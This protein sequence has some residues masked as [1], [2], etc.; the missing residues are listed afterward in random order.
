[1][2]TFKSIFILSAIL[3][4][5]TAC[6]QEKT[7]E[8][9]EEQV[10]S[11]IHS[12]FE[13]DDGDEIIDKLQ[14]SDTTKPSKFSSVLLFEDTLK[15]LYDA[16]NVDSIT[17][18]YKVFR[19]AMIG[20]YSLRQ[21]GR[22]KNNNEIISIIDFT[23]PSTE[24]RFYTIDL[25]NKQYVFNT[26]VSHGRNTGG[27]KATKFSN[28][29]QSFQTSLGLCTT[30]KT[31]VGSK[32][33]SMRL[34]GEEAGVNDNVFKRAIVMHDAPYVSES[35]IK[36]YGRIG[37]SLGC[38]AIP[39]EIAK[40][41]INTIK[42]GTVLFSYYNDENYIKASKFLNIEALVQKMNLNELSKD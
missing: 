38:P 42:D 40:E 24:K 19:F 22:L 39:K 2:N 1:M 32:G 28:K 29:P 35:W 8:E 36:K 12:V 9:E 15:N 6:A 11:E 25:V 13:Y 37:R 21:D 34:H 31:Y 23:L 4:C 14:A 30:G 33:Y 7:A 16:I 5:F 10:E 20:Y 18:D 27:N 26:L 41:V 17:L 3:T